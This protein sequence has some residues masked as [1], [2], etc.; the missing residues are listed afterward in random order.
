MFFQIKTEPDVQYSATYDT[1]FNSKFY[2]Y[3]V[4]IIYKTT[5]SRFVYRVLALSQFSK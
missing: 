3:T 1:I 4:Y 5:T 2:E